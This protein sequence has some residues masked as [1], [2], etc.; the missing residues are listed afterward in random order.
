MDQNALVRWHWCCLDSVGDFVSLFDSPLR[1]SRHWQ[2]PWRHLQAQNPMLLQPPGPAAPPGRPPPSPVG[3]PAV[4]HCSLHVPRAR[5]TGHALS[6]CPWEID[7][8]ERML[9]RKKGLNNK[10]KDFRQ[11][12]VVCPLGGF[13]HAG[14]EQGL[15]KGVLEHPCLE[16]VIPCRDAWCTIPATP[17]QQMFESQTS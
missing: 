4:G 14:P 5:R 8:F 12:S 2:K 3:S 10:V 16:T 6:Q 15:Q 1:A 7:Q 13:R 11:H 17:C 9:V